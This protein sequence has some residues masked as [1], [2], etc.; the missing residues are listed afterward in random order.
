[1]LVRG[2]SL[3]FSVA[4]CRGCAGPPR[5]PLGASSWRDR[6][7]ASR[8]RAEPLPEVAG[9]ASWSR[10]SRRRRA[11]RRSRHMDSARQAECLTSNKNYSHGGTLHENMF[12]L[13]LA[14]S[15][16][17]WRTPTSRR[18]LCPLLLFSFLF[19]PLL[20]W[21]SLGRQSASQAIF[22][23]PWK[24]WGH[25]GP[26]PPLSTPDAALNLGRSPCFHHPPLSLSFCACCSW[27]SSLR[28]SG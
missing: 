20:T 17:P 27:C 25:L 26:G 11:S 21:T 24:S 4:P 10:C 5:D 14:L 8:D 6:G 19:L 7:W 9:L 15:S 2:A 3:D 23:H 18:L 16:S 12:S 13:P 22:G 28:V 1:M